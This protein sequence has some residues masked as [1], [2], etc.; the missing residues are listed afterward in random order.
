[1]NLRS[2]LRLFGRAIVR[3]DAPPTQFDA[4]PHYSLDTGIEVYRNNYRGNLQDALAGAYPVIG[5]LVGEDFFHML[6]RDYISQHASRTANLFDYGAELDEFLAAYV[7]ARS[8]AYLPDVA[9]LEWACHVAYFVADTP[10]FVISR[11]ARVATDDY[12]SLLLHV[13]PAC[14]IVPSNYPITA[15]WQAHQSVADN[16]FHIDL[17]SGPSIALINRKDDVVNVSELTEDEACW[18]AAI[19]R[20]RSFGE[21]TN[22]TLARFPHFNLQATLLKLV[23][24]DVLSDY[25]MGEAS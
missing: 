1:M 5:Q 7:P 20:G 8:L 14:R 11:L 9:K 6:A 12:P 15:I 23:A 22:T 19:M 21:A 4:S 16:D 2:E 10:S 25:S 18:L 24:L 3:G 13:H 17:A